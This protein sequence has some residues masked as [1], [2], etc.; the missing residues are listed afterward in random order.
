[1]SQDIA[2]P[3]DESSFDGGLHDSS[4]TWMPKQTIGWER[5]GAGHMEKNISLNDLIQAHGL[6]LFFFSFEYV[7]L[8]D[9]K[10]FTILFYKKNPKYIHISLPKP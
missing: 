1:M 2:V 3:H 7:P 4:F 6:F 9:V 8:R 5:S 10:D